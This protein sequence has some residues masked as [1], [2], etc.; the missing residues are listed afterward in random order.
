MGRFA[1]RAAEIADE[2]EEYAW[3]MHLAEVERVAAAVLAIGLA[4]D[5]PCTAWDVDAPRR[6]DAA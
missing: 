4:L 1:E 3:S 5:A 6:S 2:L